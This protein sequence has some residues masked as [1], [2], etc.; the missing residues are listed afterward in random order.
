MTEVCNHHWMP[1]PADSASAMML[2]GQTR[3]LRCGKRATAEDM[4]AVSVGMVDE[5]ARG[6]VVTDYDPFGR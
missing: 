4:R 6:S 5:V 3:C 2:V 1:Q